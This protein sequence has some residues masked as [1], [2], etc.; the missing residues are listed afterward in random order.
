MAILESLNQTLFLMINATPDSAPI[1]IKLATFIA[2]DVMRLLP[3]LLVVLWLWGRAELR[4]TILKSLLL[5][6][7]ALIGNWA[8]GLIWPHPRPFAV[9]IGYTFLAHDPTPSFPSN[10]GSIFAMMALCWCFS[11]ARGWGWVMAV[12]G[13]AVAW[14][15]VYLGVHF[16]LDMLGALLVSI[17]W[18]A[19][20]SPLWA[21][22]GAALTG[23]LESLYRQLLAKPIAAGL[24]RR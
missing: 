14:S 10:H 20:L 19:A 13:L 6:A 3:A 17:A 11:A 4:D 23:A 16:P 18:C 7:V 15:R 22:K 21:R 1:S 8:I 2:R 5:T 9:P 24:I 12:S